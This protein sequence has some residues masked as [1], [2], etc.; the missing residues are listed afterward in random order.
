MKIDTF[1]PGNQTLK[2]INSIPALSV[3]MSLG[4]CWVPGVNAEENRGPCSMGLRIPCGG[5]SKTFGAERS[6]HV[7]FIDVVVKGRG[8]IIFVLLFYFFLRPCNTRVFVRSAS[9]SSTG[10]TWSSF[11]ER[12]RVRERESVCVC[13][14][15]AQ[16]YP[17]LCDPIDCSPPGS[18]IHGIL[19]ARTQEWV[20]I[21][22]S[23]FL[24]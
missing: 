12:E 6:Q 4:G 19:Q 1:C 11:L 24:Q 7:C 9:T 14:W 15:V 17:T 22:F 5:L 13:V 10:I 18:S 2:T 21:S 20:A 16:S 3:Q 8:Q 23:T